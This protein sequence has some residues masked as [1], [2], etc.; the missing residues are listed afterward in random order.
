MPPGPVSVNSRVPADAHADGAALRPFVSREAALGVGSGAARVERALEDAE[1]RVALCSELGTF[2]AL[3]GRAQDRVVVDLSL[4]VLVAK[5]LH[6]LGRALDIREQKRDGAAGQ[7]RHD[8]DLVSAEP[9]S[10]WRRS[11]S[12]FR[13]ASPVKS[14]KG[15]GGRRCSLTDPFA[16]T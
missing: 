6:E 7:C 2:P 12:S 4:D 13:Y 14:S 9:S 16:R 5:L 3:E 8:A 15:C 10:G 11:L 1:E